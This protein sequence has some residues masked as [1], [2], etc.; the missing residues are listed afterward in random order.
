MVDTA[1]NVALQEAAN[2]GT[3]KSMASIRQAIS[4]LGLQYFIEHPEGSILF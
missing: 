1:R 4:D 2:A 3:V